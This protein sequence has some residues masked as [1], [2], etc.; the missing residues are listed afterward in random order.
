M[1]CD[2]S[3]AYCSSRCKKAHISYHLKNE[4]RRDDLARENLQQMQP[5]AAHTYNRIYS[6]TSTGNYQKN[7]TNRRA[8][9][10]LQP[11]N[12]QENIQPQL[13]QQA[14]PLQANTNKRRES[15][16]GQELFYQSTTTTTTT[17]KLSKFASMNENNRR[18]SVAS[19]VPT[20]QELEKIFSTESSNLNRINPA[21]KNVYTKRSSMKE[22][23]STISN[24]FKRFSAFE[25]GSKSKTSKQPITMDDTASSVQ[26]VRPLKTSTAVCLFDLSRRQSL[27]EVKKE[28]ELMIN[29][30][31]KEPIV[32]KNSD[33]SSHTSSLSSDSASASS[34]GQHPCTIKKLKTSNENMK[35]SDVV[36]RTKKVEVENEN[37]F[38]DGSIHKRRHSATAAILSSSGKTTSMTRSAEESVKMSKGPVPTNDSLFYHGK[39]DHQPNNNPNELVND[40]S[41]H[42]KSSSS[43]S[44]SK[45]NKKNDEKNHTSDD[46]EEFPSSS[47]AN[48]SNSKSFC[49]HL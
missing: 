5:S 12:Y 15:S 49:I 29:K 28:S 10:N 37:N 22:T 35:Q 48:S 31:N 8:S 34:S 25:D 46:N 4:C 36:K 11:K 17:K 23:K 7:P 40:Y 19:N 24:A 30:L 41:N 9:D 44:R 42:T 43:S 26:F 39:Y 18:N 6:S 13:V 21:T 20:Y 45:T 47:S 33:S 2:G 32:T 38:L 16:A 3:A 27:R 1:S 14:P